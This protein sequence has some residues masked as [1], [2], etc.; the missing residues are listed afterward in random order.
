MGAEDQAVVDP[1]PSMAGKIG[2]VP[3][4]SRLMQEEKVT[5]LAAAS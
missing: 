2:E 3:G 4:P 1:G 5:G